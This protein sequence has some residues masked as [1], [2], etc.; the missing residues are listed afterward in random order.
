MNKECEFCKNGLIKFLDA[1]RQQFP[2]LYFLSNEEML[3]IY[4]QKEQTMRSLM[5]GTP[6]TFL[7]TIFAGIEKVIIDQRT[8]DITAVEAVDGEQLPLIAVVPTDVEVEKWLLA[9]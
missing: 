6:K 4:G 8:N 5:V 7:T 1:K 2:R 9:L 3:T